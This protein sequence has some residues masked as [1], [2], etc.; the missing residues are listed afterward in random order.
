MNNGIYLRR[1]RKVGLPPPAVEGGPAGRACIATLLKNLEPLGYVFS[2]KLVQGCLTL[3]TEQLG[4]LY[5]ELL[6]HLEKSRG[7]HRKH[8]PM[9]PGFP[10]QVMALPEAELYLNALLHY[11]TDG[12]YFPNGAPSPAT[13]REVEPDAARSGLPAW[14][15]RIRDHLT[16]D[17]LTERPPLDEEPGPTVL[18]LGSIEEFEALFTAVAGANVSL[19]EQDREDLAWYVR[20]YGDDIERLLPERVPQKENVAYLAGLLMAHTSQAPAFLERYVKTATDVLR[21]AVAQSGGDVSLAQSTRFR[22]FSRPERRLL[23]RLLDRCPAPVEDMLRWKGRWIRLGERLHPGEH[24]QTFA[25][26]AAAFDVL[27]RDQPY[28]TFNGAIENALETRDVAGAVERL[29][30]RPGDFARRLDHL[31]RL[32]RYAQGSIIDR[33]ARVARSVSTPVLLQVAQHFRGRT[34]PRPLRVFFPKGQLAKAQA[35]PNKLPPLPEAVCGAVVEAC[36]TALIER[37]K[38][39]PPLGPSYV[40]PA[41]RDYLVPFAVRS[42]SRSF[43]TVARGSRLPMPEGEVLRFFVWWTDGDDRTDIDLSATLLDAEFNYLDIVSYYNLKAFGGAHSGDIVDAPNGASEFI[44]LTICKLLERKVRYVVMSLSSYTE[45]PYCELP[46]CFAGWMARQ[47]PDSGEIYEPRTVQDRLDLT[48]DTCI[49][50]PLVFD[51]LDRKVIWCDMALRRHPRWQNN[52]HAN[53]NGINLTVQAMVGLDRPNLYD[54]F[55]LHGRAR[56]KLV[57]SADVAQTIF[58]V[59]R[60]TPFHPERIAAEFLL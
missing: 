35:V 60:E 18:D 3:S 28:P 14:I 46:E 45:Q 10:A 27:R 39:L 23:L 4:A 41:L 20:R 56:G 9:Y 58:S 31:L 1:L 49:A 21:L 17:V 13:D 57:E 7:A 12:A 22:N 16:Q 36:E 55:R 6:A 8:R 54:L 34:S 24:A 48:A 5:R 37:F 15:G 25:N 38:L 40:D 26:A 50:L 30:A 43:R 53:L 19:S 59:E 52:V 51:L 44:D 42:A 47:K 29:A 2:E 33:F 11:W 32:E